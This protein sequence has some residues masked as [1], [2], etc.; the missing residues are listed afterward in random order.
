MQDEHLEFQLQQ[1]LQ[2][3]PTLSSQPI[4]VVCDGGNV[5]L[6]GSVQSFRRKLQAQQIVSTFR[7]VREVVNELAVD[8]PQP[9]S[10]PRLLHRVRQALEGEAVLCPHSIRIDAQDGAVTNSGYVSSGAETEL[11]TDIVSGVDGVRDVQDMLMINPDRALFNQELAAT[12]KAAT[13]R[14]IGMEREHL[15]VAVVDESAQL[16][17]SV[18]AIW[19]KEM[20]EQTVR[21]FQ[22][23][24][25]CNDIYVQP[26]SL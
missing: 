26:E 22:I 8:P 23:T 2:A 13:G 18:D 16:N 9:I 11:V 4:K 14:V 21:R 19:K 24:N 17:G 3:A 1:S 6:R 12:I 7:D 25:V 20:A 15:M 10:D 5:T